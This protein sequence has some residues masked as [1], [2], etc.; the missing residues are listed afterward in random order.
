MAKIIHLC[1]CDM[2]AFAAFIVLPHLPNN[3]SAFGLTV[4]LALINLATFIIHFYI[5]PQAALYRLLYDM[6]V[7]LTWRY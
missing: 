3:S 2:L 7:C 5:N 6:V 1:F 4:L